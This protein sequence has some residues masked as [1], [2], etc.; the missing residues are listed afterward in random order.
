MSGLTGMSLPKDSYSRLVKSVIKLHS[1]T[2]ILAN[3]A[4]RT[5]QY[6]K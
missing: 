5:L 6:V 3:V 1:F 4:N 2:Q